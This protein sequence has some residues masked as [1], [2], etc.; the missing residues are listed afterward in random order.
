MLRCADAPM[1]T[2]EVTKTSVK[3]ADGNI[4]SRVHIENLKILCEITSGYRSAGGSQTN[5]VQTNVNDA[6]K[7]FLPCTALATHPSSARRTC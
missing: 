5:N 1:L 7:Q 2:G 6:I 4:P 3:T